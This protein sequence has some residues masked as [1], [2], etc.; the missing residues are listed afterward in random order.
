MN[1][2]HFHTAT[3]VTNLAP[4]ETRLEIHGNAARLDK[5]ADTLHVVR[6]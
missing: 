1:Q 5:Q 6:D 2:A 4:L 3:S